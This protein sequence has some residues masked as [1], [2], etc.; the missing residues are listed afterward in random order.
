MCQEGTEW[1]WRSKGFGVITHQFTFGKRKKYRFSEGWVGLG[2]SPDCSEKPPTTGVQTHTVQPV[3]SRC[4]TEIPRTPYVSYAKS[5]TFKFTMQLTTAHCA[6]EWHKTVISS[7]PASTSWR[8]VPL[9]TIS[10]VEGRG[11]WPDLPRTNCGDSI[12]GLHLQSLRHY[13]W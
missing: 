11:V 6:S 12:A 8:K 9:P 5:T 3:A 4:S 13:A 7:I 2:V 10:G 1:S